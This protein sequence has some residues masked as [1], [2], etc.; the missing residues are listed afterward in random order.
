MAKYL[1][2]SYS[3]SLPLRIYDQLPS[4]LRISGENDPEI[5][6]ILRLLSGNAKLTHN[7]SKTTVKSRTNYFSGNFAPFQNW[8]KEFPQ[9]ISEDTSVG[10]ISTFINCTKYANRSFYSNILAEISHFILHEKRGSHTSAFIYVY[11]ILEKISYAFPL[12]YASKTQDFLRS[13]NQLKDLMTGSGEK[14]ELG[15]FKTFV[16]TINKDDSITDTSIDVKI[17]ATYSDVQKQMFKAV[18]EVIDDSVIHGDTTEFEKLSIKYCDMGGF[19]ISV[20]NRFFHN[21]NGGAENIESNKIVDSDELF[22]FINAASMHWLSMVFLQVT[23]HSLSEFQRH[24]QD[25][26]L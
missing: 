16:K 3:D 21:L 20:R 7:Y 2:F 15:F 26:A 24:R 10:D 23:H 5:L 17:D 4:P 11:R 14:K 18:R 6:L 19:I 8:K 13:F 9:L 25:A 12:I 22:R 1:A